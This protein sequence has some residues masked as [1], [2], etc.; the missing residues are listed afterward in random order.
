M[1][2]S[3]CGN[4]ITKDPMSGWDGGHNAEPV[5]PGRCCDDCNETVVIPQRLAQIFAQQGSEKL[6]YLSEK[7]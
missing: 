6:D 4:K 7:G 2:C 1:N 5:A 3:I